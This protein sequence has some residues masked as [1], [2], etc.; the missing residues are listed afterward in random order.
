MTTS[1]KLGAFGLALAAVF[2]A[3]L[4]VGSAIGPVSATDRAAH[5]AGAPTVQSAPAAQ[6][7]TGWTDGVDEGGQPQGLAAAADGYT[8]TPAATALP[9]VQ[10]AA[11]TFQIIGPAGRAVT[12][13]TPVHDQQLQLVVVRRDL[14][15]YQHLHP[16]MAPD[17]TWSAALTRPGP[18]A[19]KAFADFQPAGHDRELT[20]ALDLSAAGD[21]APVPLAAPTATFTVDGY[22][23]ALVG[24]LVAGRESA[25]TFTVTGD[26]GRPVADL[27][28]YLAAYGHLVVLRTG[29]LAYLPVHP[30]AVLGDGQTPGGLKLAFGADVPTPGLYRLFLEFKAGDA[31]HTAEFTV[32]AEKGAT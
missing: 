27:Q 9:A 16:T 7:G 21:F 4:V 31:V 1:V 2:V 17:G 32:D 11:F 13:F 8:I 5:R 3:A 20:L 23:A 12:A 26:G 22:Q 25:V 24:R 29:D 19:Y 28:P 30:G 10:P 18:G 6:G 15:G 14:T